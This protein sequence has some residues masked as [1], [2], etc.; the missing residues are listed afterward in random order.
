[1]TSFISE[2]NIEDII[3]DGV[4]ITAGATGIFFGLKTAGVKLPS[5][6]CYVYRKTYRWDLWRS[7]SERLCSLQEM[8]QQVIQQKNFL[9]LWS[10]KN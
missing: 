6:G 9:A 10:Y 2:K 7:I 8:D 4:I 3:K 1:M 5:P